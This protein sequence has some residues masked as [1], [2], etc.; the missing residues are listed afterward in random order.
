MPSINAEVR[1]QDAV[2]QLTRY[3]HVAPELLD[4]LD[5]IACINDDICHGRDPSVIRESVQK[6]REILDTVKPVW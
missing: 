6:A 2:D 4:L 5:Q 3:S 1:I